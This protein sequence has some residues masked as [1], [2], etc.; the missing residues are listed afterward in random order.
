MS[1]ETNGFYT[2]IDE[3][4]KDTSMGRPHVVILGAGASLATFPNGDKSGKKLPLMTNFI[5]V[6]GLS[7][8]LDRYS[9]DYKDRNFEE[10]YSDLYENS[11][12]KELVESINTA[13]WNYF[14]GLELPAY[15]TLYDHLVLSLRNKDLIATFNWDPFLYYA[16]WR[17]HKR[18]KLPYVVYL[19]G[20]VA[21]GYCET[22]NTKGWI[23]SKCSKCG[24]KFI[25]SRLLYPI[26]QKGYTQD[27][28]TRYEWETLKDALSSAYV[29]T[30]FGYS[31]PQSDI[32]AIEL[33][34]GAWGNKYQR[35]LE[36]IEIIDTKGEQE[37]RDAWNDFIHTHHYNTSNDFY[38]SL[39]GLFPRR[40]CEAEWNYS[41]P[42]KPIFYPHNPIPRNLG[43]KELWEW[44][45]PLIEAENKKAQI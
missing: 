33:M 23:N 18:A 37:L 3:L 38:K 43:F 20:N 7:S 34:K 39:M 21:V 12:Y 25:P 24:K 2:S 44:Y 36:Q 6:V 1:H 45:S 32:E 11:S 13:V 31:A 26:K 9:I 27:K 15:P 22:D 41:M 40:T 35:N 4:I 10:V 5:D 8:I 16:C 29:L 14:S 19:H 28:F 30:V 42:A 17:N